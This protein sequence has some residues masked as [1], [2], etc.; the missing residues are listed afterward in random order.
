MTKIAKG[1]RYDGNLSSES[2]RNVDAHVCAMVAW[3]WKS[4][5]CSLRQSPCYERKR[6]WE[7]TTAADQW[8]NVTAAWDNLVKAVSIDIHRHV[9]YRKEGLN[10]FF[11]QRAT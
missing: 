9:G 6:R 11:L 4:R 7:G 3:S 1:M 2:V 8:L 5:R 10:F